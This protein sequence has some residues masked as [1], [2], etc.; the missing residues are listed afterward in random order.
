MNNN[1]VTVG[2]LLLTAT[3][4]SLGV[5]YCRARK[6]APLPF[7]GWG[8]A[9]IILLSEALLLLRVGWVTIFFTP[10][11][12]TGYLLLVDAL[13]WSL[14]GSSRIGRTPR[15][16]LALAFW[17]V[18]LWLI[19][20]AYNLRLR[21]WVYVGTALNPVIENIG[22]IWAF[23]TIWPAIF[24]TSD[25]ILA[26]GLFRRHDL[27]TSETRAVTHEKGPG[28]G[29]PKQ[30]ARPSAIGRHLIPASSRGGIFILGVVMVTLPLLLP[31]RV[32][33]YLFGL[34]W[35]GFVPLLD[36]LNYSAKG[37]SLLRDYE[38]GDFSNLLAFLSAGWICGIL[39]EFWNYWA[40]GKWLY[41]FPILRI[42]KIF[43][44]PALGYFGFPPFAVECFVMYEFLR[45][46][47]KRLWANSSDV[48]TMPS[49]T[50]QSRL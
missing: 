17:S 44:M 50:T 49:K 23:A 9:A 4:F 30:S 45:T 15:Q 20:E 42:W 48:T 26:F 19:F 40:A 38:A 3:L 22:Y 16:F 46:I 31:A 39:W 35:I 27:V 10:I 37:R 34:V 1:H 32:G 13:V 24:E 11:A 14:Q 28:S 36:P 21:N 7:W 6:V 29:R 41:V 47:R 8:G 18:P 43:E 12:W 33:A 5:N 25:L 2:I